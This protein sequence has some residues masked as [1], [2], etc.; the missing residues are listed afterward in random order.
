[1]AKA[2]GHPWPGAQVVTVPGGLACLAGAAVLSWPM[3]FLGAPL[4]F[5]D[6][7]PYAVEGQAVVQGL[8]GLLPGG[9]GAAAGSVGELAGQANSLRSVYY[10]AFVHLAAQ[11][12][13]GFAGPALLQGAM[14]LFLAG[15][16]VGPEAAAPAADRLLAGALVVALTPLAWFASYLMPDVLAAAVVLHACLLVRGVDA[17]SPRQCAAVGLVAGF[18]IVS[19]HG[20]IP[21]SGAVVA[22][23]LALRLAARRPLLRAAALGLAPLM[24]A[25]GANMAL[26]ALVLDG[27]S[28]APRRLPIL[29]ARSIADG[30]ARWHLEAHCADENYAVCGYF[31]T[32]PDTVHD[33]LW[34]E[35]GLRDGPTELLALVRAE[36]P[37]ILW[38]AFLEYPAQQVWSLAGNTLVQLVSI[39]TGEILAGR[40]VFDAAGRP[41]LE[42]D[43]ARGRGLLAAYDVVLPLSVLAGLGMIGRMA[44]RD[45]LRAGPHERALLAVVTVGLLANGAIFGGLSAPVDRYQT[46]L[47]WLLPALA[48]LFWLARRRRE[49]A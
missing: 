1:M 11:T 38:R 25:V 45:G 8:L 12:P 46:R 42:I 49:G 24:L 17:L 29:L 6:S 30:P 10:A 40:A 7:L 27:P 3:L 19:H 35:G 2:A 39:G 26:G 41:Q 37:V 13:L 31:E 33:T 16:L 20:Y 44:L 14:V 32:I 36:E 47:A 9:D 22:L 4:F 18:A 5:L 21:L 34:A 23:A 28:V 43:R 48:A 15:P